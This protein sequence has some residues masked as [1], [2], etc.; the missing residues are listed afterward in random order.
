V[1]ASVSQWA[2]EWGSASEKESDLEK[3]RGT[4]WG[5][6]SEKASAKGWGLVLEMG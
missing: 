4:E 5:Q 2:A 3:A 6:A 1:R